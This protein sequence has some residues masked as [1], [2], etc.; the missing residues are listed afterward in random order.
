MHLSLKASIT[1]LTSP[2]HS[3][4]LEFNKTVNVMIQY[5]PQIKLNQFL[6]ITLKNNC[7]SNIILM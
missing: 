1:K 3:K 4:P 6:K 5:K 7:A 2:S